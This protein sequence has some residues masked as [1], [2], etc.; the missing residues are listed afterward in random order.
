MIHK[1]TAGQESH[2]NAIYS[3]NENNKI[4]HIQKIKSKKSRSV[5]YDT[6]FLLVLFSVII[7]EIRP[8]WYDD[9]QHEKFI[10]EN[11]SPPV[12]SM[13]ETDVM[14]DISNNPRST[15]NISDIIEDRSETESTSKSDNAS[16]KSNNS[17]YNLSRPDDFTKGIFEIAEDTSKTSDNISHKS[18]NSQSN[19]SMIPESTKGTSKTQYT[20]H[21]IDWSDEIFLPY[22]RD[23]IVIESHKLLFFPLEKNACTEWKVL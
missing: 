22:E 23:P 8:V 11:N 18:N 21:D 5:L 17:P 20:T 19:L 6:L 15:N 2:F 4:V 9:T 10:P 14:S 13:K 1:R 7:Y 12:R 16:H 3:S